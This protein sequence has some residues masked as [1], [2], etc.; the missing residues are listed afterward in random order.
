MAD[1]LLLPVNSSDH[2]SIITINRN[3]LNGLML[4]AESVMTQKCQDF[5]WVI[6][7]GASNDGGAEYV[8]GIVRSNTIAISEPDT[9]IYNAMNKGTRLAH[10]EYCLFLNSGDQLFDVAVTKEII[11][12]IS[13]KE[14]K[15]IFRGRIEGIKGGRHQYFSYLAPNITGTYFFEFEIPHQ[16]TLIKR[17]CLLQH[18]YD[19]NY[20][21]IADQH[22]FR[23]F[24]IL[25]WGTDGLLPDG[26]ILAKYDLSGCSSGCPEAH[27]ESEKSFL[28][29]LG[30]VVLKDY[31]T[32]L[33]GG[34][35][36]RWCRKFGRSS[37]RRLL[38][39][40]LLLPLV[41]AVSFISIMR[42]W[43][44]KYKTF[45]KRTK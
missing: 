45:I 18:P 17:E 38:A 37:K 26:R 11:E 42:N 6:I 41:I 28:S 27:K 7:D 30:P 34:C 4:T 22:F 16:G 12:F 24:F 39:E 10:G 2:L 9:G 35:L 19:E 36:E 20:R 33:Y 3:N 29:L 13:S 8:K 15:D 1:L 5:E 40:F 31:R 25:G 23:S 43:V 21:I 44:D 32:L 14:G